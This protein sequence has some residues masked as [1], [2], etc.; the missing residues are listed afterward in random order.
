MKPWIKISLTLLIGF[1]LGVTATGLAIHHYF[2]PHHPPGIQ[3]ADRILKRLSSR[4]DL[5]ED[6][7]AKVEALLKQ[8]LPKTEALR[9]EGDAKFKSLR[10]SFDSQLRALFNLDQQKKLDEMV[11]KWEQRQKT[12]SRFLEIG[13]AS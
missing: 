5:T 6:Q 4:Y 2:H 10:D 9:N 12:E 1:L 3:D 8:E 13:R 11:A 7:K